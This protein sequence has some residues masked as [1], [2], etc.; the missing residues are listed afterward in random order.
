[1]VAIAFTTLSSR[2]PSSST[3]STTPGMDTGSESSHSLL[4]LVLLIFLALLAFFTI[5][6]YLI[7]R[8]LHRHKSNFKAEGPRFAIRPFLLRADASR[9]QHED[10]LEK[11]NRMLDSAINKS[12]ISKPTL[13]SS[14]CEF[15]LSDTFMANFEVT[16]TDTSNEASYTRR[17]NP[18]P[19]VVDITDDRSNVEKDFVEPSAIPSSASGS[20]SHGLGKVTQASDTE[21]LSSKEAIGSERTPGAQTD[22]GP[23]NIE[24]NYATT[25]QIST[26]E[27]TNENRTIG[28]N[29]ANLKPDE[30]VQATRKATEITRNALGTDRPVGAQSNADSLLTSVEAGAP[31]IIKGEYAEDAALAGNRIDDTLENTNE[32]NVSEVSIVTQPPREPNGPEGARSISVLSNASTKFDAPKIVKGD[33]DQAAALATKEFNDLNSL[34]ISFEENAAIHG[35]DSEMS[36]FS[37]DS[38]SSFSSEMDELSKSWEE[39]DKSLTSLE[40]F[41]KSKTAY[42]MLGGLGEPNDGEDDRFDE[43][44]MSSSFATMDLCQLVIP[45]SSYEESMSFDSPTFPSCG[46]LVKRL[47]TPRSRDDAK[48]ALLRSRLD[49]K[50]N[51]TIETIVPE[52]IQRLALGGGASAPEDYEPER[53]P[54]TCGSIRKEIRQ[55]ALQFSATPYRPGLSSP[56]ASATAISGPGCASSD[57]MRRLSQE[58]LRLCDFTFGISDQ[59]SSSEL[60]VEVLKKQYSHR[61]RSFEDTFV[62]AGSLIEDCDPFSGSPWVD[63]I[64][65]STEPLF[66]CPDSSPG[67]PEEEDVSSMIDDTGSTTTLPGERKLL[68]ED[69]TCATDLLEPLQ[70]AE[71]ASSSPLPSLSQ[72]RRA[73][74][75]VPA[76]LATLSK[77]CNRMPTLKEEDE[78]A[79]T[80]RPSPPVRMTISSLQSQ[81]APPLPPRNPARRPLSPIRIG[82]KTRNTERVT[83]S[84]TGEPAYR[85]EAPATKRSVS[86][87]FPPSIDQNQRQQIRR[88]PPVV[89]RT[90]QDVSSAQPPP[91]KVNESL[92]QKN[93]L[94]PAR[95]AHYLT[96]TQGS[97]AKRRN[98][99]DNS[100]KTPK[101][102]P[103]KILGIKLPDRSRKQISVPRTSRTTAPSLR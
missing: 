63:S 56:L 73:P 54:R 92:Q 47:G 12:K 79:S 64:I 29:D 74:S 16:R 9:E 53:D 32:Q 19:P 6:A 91:S 77:P 87:T 62:N 94:R 21:N 2:D 8:F 86:Q 26:C 34:Q 66:Y 58:I 49:L 89:S 75:P 67:P 40:N 22:E 71:T 20:V 1:M 28:E 102:K 3:T 52:P 82:N 103:K 36:Y 76:K 93:K 59:H 61:F 31:E 41:V 27:S 15:V 33:D 30:E 38:S 23:A 60:L 97:E 46:V 95:F 51:P 96:P 18:S 68:S 13:V 43:P 4:Y 37:S 83:C 10:D 81:E 39:V 50:I 85:K 5:S 24:I 48:T 90:S 100:I 14:T 55:W 101:D 42:S 99:S 88:G 65:P 69:E 98:P 70:V 7:H 45:D 57:G 35:I 17:T 78:E 84:G 72:V 11:G 44:A 25:L 80:S